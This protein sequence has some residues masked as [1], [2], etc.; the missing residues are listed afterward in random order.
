MRGR[1][2]PALLFLA[3]ALVTARP[4]FAQPAPAAPP[5]APTTP[6]APEENT[7]PPVPPKIEVSD[8]Q[9]APLPAAPHILASWN[10]A[11]Q[12]IS[13]RTVDVVLARL[14][15]ERSK[16]QLRQS[17]AS[18]L[19]TVN[20]NGQITHN[21]IQQPNTSASI[22]SAS[23]G[24]GTIESAQLVVSQPILA[25]RAWYAIGTA[26]LAV[27]AAQLSSEDRRRTALV[28]VASAIISVFTAERIA[29]INRVGLKSSLQRLDL[30]QRK[31]RLGD[32]TKLDVLRAE[33]DG[34]AARATLI[35]GDESLRKAREN[36]GLSLG[37]MEPY[38]VPPTIS[39]NEIVQTVAGA[40]SPS[41]VNQRADVLAARTNVQIA[42]RQIRD[43]KL[44]FAPT[45]TLNST[46][47]LASSLLAS[48]KHYSWA[49]Q[50]MLTI[51]IWDGGAR[52]GSLRVAKANAEQ[53][54]AR[55]DGALRS[56]TVE[57]N[58]AMRAV[59]V[60]EQ[61]RQVAE[62]NRDL[63]REAARLATRAFEVGAGT[64][65][66][67]VDT[68]RR[69]REAELNLAVREFELIQAKIAALLATA[70]CK[71]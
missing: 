14:E 47:T 30:A 2:T 4:G 40:C 69:E 50:G 5:P 11:L 27:K 58:Q 37:S 7:E 1:L 25:P 22:I 38:G 60:A 70:S 61:A 18:A 54:K 26:E 10:E 48:G 9:L 39:L 28:Q 19:P 3:A 64:S 21:L 35:S 52:Y 24:G 17:L 63:A 42:Q 68:G 8:P 33:Q 12:I 44:A 65:F 41:S 59:M 45:A 66:D 31:L 53:Q 57:S 16:G 43:A 6:A 62:Q 55:L 23:F 49:I 56:A 15:V 20:I 32:G 46:T 36:L 13:A 67:L 34:A 51:P 71:Y 29:E